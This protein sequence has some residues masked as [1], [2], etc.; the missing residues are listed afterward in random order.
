MLKRKSN[1]AE[2]LKREIKKLKRKNQ[3]AKE[4]EIQ[5]KQIINSKGN[6]VARR[7]R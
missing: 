5:L 1:S 4:I 7:E 6:E 3:D 2:D